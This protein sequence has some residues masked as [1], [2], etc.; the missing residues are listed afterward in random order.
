[1]VRNELDPFYYS[2]GGGVRHGE[3]LETAAKREVL[4][5]TG[6]D[7]AIDRLLFI[8]ENFFNGNGSTLNGLNCHELAFY[9]LMIWNPENQLT[10]KSTSM[11]DTPE[12]LEW[13]QISILSNLSV[14][15]YPTFFAVELLNLPHGVKHIV[16]YE[17]A[18]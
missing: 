2:V 18:N 11:E 16:T 9:Y 15:V 3:S 6:C 5:E 10:S 14:P 17:P 12:H 4:E 1:M 7:L 8:H 13:I